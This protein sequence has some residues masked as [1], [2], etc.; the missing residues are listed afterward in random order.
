MFKAQTL[1]LVIICCSPK[2][3]VMAVNQ[4]YAQV[5][6]LITEDAQQFAQKQQN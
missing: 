3:N 2:E 6:L 1:L 5:T 4:K